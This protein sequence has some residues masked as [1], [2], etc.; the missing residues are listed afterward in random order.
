MAELLEPQDIMFTPFEP[1]LKNRY[2]MQIDG[3]NAYMIKTSKRPSIDA[4]EVPLE[5]MNVTNEKWEI[6][7]INNT[8]T[9]AL[10]P[11]T[12][13]RDTNNKKDMNEELADKLLKLIRDELASSQVNKENNSA[14]YL[15]GK[16]EA[17]SKVLSA[18]TI[19]E[20]QK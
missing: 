10:S 15:L 4:K 8:R 11:F 3:I 12:G 17:Y 2:I 18:L 16:N 19:K 1:K 14:E 20:L 13:P 7:E 5:Q 9:G 6:Q